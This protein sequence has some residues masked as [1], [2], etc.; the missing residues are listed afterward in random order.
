MKKYLNEVKFTLH[1]EEVLTVS[2]TIDSGAGSAALNQF[3]NYK[4]AMLAI[5]GKEVYV[6]FHAVIK[7]EVTKTEQEI[8]GPTDD[9]CKK[10][11]PCDDGE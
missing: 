7:V 5:D 11:C 2:D 10:I 8:E 4:T 1:N 9:N 6:P 3:L